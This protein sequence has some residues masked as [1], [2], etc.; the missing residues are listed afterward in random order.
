M[1]DGPHRYPYTSQEKQCRVEN[2][3]VVRVVGL[4]A[5]EE[6]PWGQGRMKRVEASLA[7]Y[8]Q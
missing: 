3:D 8:V 1:D 2:K 5:V 7:L 6:V 4:A